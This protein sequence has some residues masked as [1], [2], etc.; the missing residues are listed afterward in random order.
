MRNQKSERSELW[1]CLLPTLAPGQSGQVTVRF[2]PN[3]SGSFSG[4]VQAGINGG[5]GSVSSSPLMGVAHKIE[6][7][8]AELNFGLVFVDSTREQKLTVKNQ[9]VTN[10]PLT[11]STEAP[12]SVVSDGS[13]GLS[14]GENREV[15]VQFNP[16]T[17]GNTQGSIRLTSGIVFKE[18]PATGM[19]YTEEEYREIL[20][21]SILATCQA[22]DE[23][24]GVR[25]IQFVPGLDQDFLFYR[26]PCPTDEELEAL[27]EFL[28][29]LGNEP[30]LDGIV[31]EQF[32]DPA[33]IIAGLNELL[34]YF[35]IAL[36]ALR[37][38]GATSEDINRILSSFVR[39]DV[40]LILQ[41][42]PGFAQFYTALTGVG[43]QLTGVLLSL[44]GVLASIPGVAP[45]LVGGSVSLLGLLYSVLTMQPSLGLSSQEWQARQFIFAMMVIMAEYPN[46]KNAI[47]A[48]IQ[49]AVHQV[50]GGLDS[51]M[52][53]LQAIVFSGIAAQAPAA[54]EVGLT[55]S[56]YNEFLEWVI[57]AY[58]PSSQVDASKLRSYMR[59]LAQMQ[60]GAFAALDQAG[61][62][63]HGGSGWSW[64]FP[65]IDV[66]LQVHVVATATIEG[67]QVTVFVHV[68]AKLGKDEVGKIVGNIEQIAQIARR[69]VASQNLGNN[70]MGTAIT[71]L[72]VFSADPDAVDQLV[73][74]LQGMNISLQT[75]VI[76]LSNEGG[77]WEIRIIGDPKD[78][79]FLDAVAAALAQALGTPYAGGN[80]NTIGELVQKMEQAITA[81]ET[82]YF[83]YSSQTAWWLAYG[84]CGGDMGCILFLAEALVEQLEEECGGPCP[85]ILSYPRSLPSR[86]P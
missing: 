71:V 21:Q 37:S 6:I 18:F 44:V 59:Y 38:S 69:W 23:S 25:N 73:T 5:Q 68:E 67:R 19:A 62:Q 58:G 4:N 15:V 72:V 61:W 84:V 13:F 47:E 81:A 31:P 29:A 42:Y 10:V 60:A 32:G 77:Q 22:S 7:S 3:E 26:M 36:N 49:S 33:N 82:A 41:Q 54:Q 40:D 27:L 51:R 86:K 2:D 79:V 55:A 28:M 65:Q 30:P 85:I 46:G 34:Y 75:P 43:P 66:D 11:V 39:G 9:G 53:A 63:I 83:G 1:G 20:R 48:V 78:Q 56:F 14:P 12:F 24:Q 57:V 64:L 17:S 45:A 50:V 52:D 80:E 74:T 70:P 8:P 76:I 16:T 35:N